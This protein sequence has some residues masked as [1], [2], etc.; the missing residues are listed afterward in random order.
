MKKNYWLDEL[1]AFGVVLIS[2]IV[3]LVRL[4]RA[5]SASRDEGRGVLFVSFCFYLAIFLFGNLFMF[6]TGNMRIGEGDMRKC[7]YTCSPFDYVLKDIKASVPLESG[8][9]VL[10]DV[11]K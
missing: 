7:N 10:V 8:A 4:S 11:G 3:F 1:F 5:H 6:D 2:E 9:F